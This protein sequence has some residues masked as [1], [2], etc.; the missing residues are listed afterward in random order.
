MVAQLTYSI[1]QDIAY[2]GQLYSL[3]QNETISRAAEGAAGIP[4]GVAVSRGTLDNQMLLGGPSF[5]GIVLRTLDQEGVANDSDVF[6]NETE[7]A[8]LIR[9]GYVYLTCPTGC[10]PGALVQYNDTTGVVDSG[11][12]GVGSTQLTNAYWDST[13]AAGDVGIVVL[14]TTA[15][16]AGS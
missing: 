16:T 14:E 4:V 7:M 11:V 13:T 12:A 3:S 15:N 5:I 8:S 2:H 10:V 1:N 6:F 9:V